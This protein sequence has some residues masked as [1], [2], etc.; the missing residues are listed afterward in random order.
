MSIK[1][2]KTF[3]LLPT[4]I[5]RLLVAGSILP[6]IYGITI[7]YNFVFAII[8]PLIIY[9]IGIFISLWVYDGFNNNEKENISFEDLMIYANKELDIN[10]IPELYELELGE[11]YLQVKMTE[12]EKKGFLNTVIKIECDI[13]LRESY[14]NR[15]MS[16][17]EKIDFFNNSIKKRIEKEPASENQLKRIASF[18]YDIVNNKFTKKM[19]SEIISAQT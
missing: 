4:G 17:E 14:L 6:L 3:L 16:K 1:L 19:C 11:K 8:T 18:G 10:I 13:N 2:L 7:S 15:K 5:K 9:W 12:K